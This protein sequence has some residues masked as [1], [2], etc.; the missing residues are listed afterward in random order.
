MHNNN[1]YLE[2]VQ[3][4]Y[5]FFIGEVTITHQ[6]RFSLVTTPTA[7]PPVFALTCISTGGP[8]TTV[9]WTRDGAPATGITS[10]SVVDL[11]AIT[12]LNTLTVTGRLL[13]NYQCRVTNDRTV[14]PATSASLNVASELSCISF[15]L[16]L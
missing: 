5:L 15:I 4:R 8:A 9:T 16:T 3:L 2:Q 12:Y 1:F 13:G 7:D 10:Q 6:L 11:M 14:Q